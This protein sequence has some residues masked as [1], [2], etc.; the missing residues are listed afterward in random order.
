LSRRDPLLEKNSKLPARMI[1]KFQDLGDGG[2]NPVETKYPSGPPVNDTGFQLERA[3][4]SA[5]ENGKAAEAAGL[6][7]GAAAN[8][9]VDGLTLRLACRATKAKK[10]EQVFQFAIALKNPLLREDVLRMCAA[11]A[12]LH[13]DGPAIWTLATEQLRQQTDRV[14]TDLGIIEG[15]AA[16]RPQRD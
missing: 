11:W 16:N 5:M 13:G 4:S 9:K 8:V 2:S 6:L 12:T 10:Y 3:A 7:N 1:A 14:A 15:L